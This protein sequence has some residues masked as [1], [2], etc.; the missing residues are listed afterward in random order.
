MHGD[1]RRQRHDHVLRPTHGN[2]EVKG[3]R[4]D[5]VGKAIPLRG[6]WDRSALHQGR[7]GKARMLRE[8]DE[9][10]GA[11]TD[12]FLGLIGHSPSL[13]G[14]MVD[15][16]QGAHFRRV[17][18]GAASGRPYDPSAFSSEGFSHVV[19][20]LEELKGTTAAFPWR[21]KTLVAERPPSSM[22]SRCFLPQ[23]H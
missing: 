4:N 15:I 16:S 5:Q 1:P 20:G 6:V 11:E 23:I 2:Q 21:T 12:P 13:T 3:E 17:S 14:E 22:T 8:R 18:P 19:H 9:G 7:R 10:P